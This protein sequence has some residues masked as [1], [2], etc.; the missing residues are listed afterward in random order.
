MTFFFLYIALITSSLS[1]FLTHTM[2]QPPG[3]I[4]DRIITAVKKGDL[5]QIKDIHRN[6]PTISFTHINLNGAPLIHVAAATHNVS[7][8]DYLIT[9]VGLNPKTPFH[10]QTILHTAAQEGSVPMSRYLIEK[11]ILDKNSTDLRGKTALDIAKARKKSSVINYLLLDPTVV[12]AQQLKKAHD[13]KQVLS[14][15]VTVHKHNTQCTICCEEKHFKEFSVLECEHSYCTDCITQHIIHAIASENSE[16][17]RCPTPECKKPLGPQ[18]TN[19]LLADNTPIKTKLSQL[20][21]KTWL[22]QQKNRAACPTPNCPFIFINERTDQFTM[23]CPS[24]KN[25]YCAKCNAPHCARISCEQAK[26]NKTVIADKEGQEKATQRWKEQNS[27]PCPQCNVS[28]EK[29]E[30]CNHMKCRTCKHEFCW[31]CMQPYEVK[32]HGPFGCSLAATQPAMPNPKRITNEQVSPLNYHLFFTRDP[33]G[34]KNLLSSRLIHTEFFERFKRLSCQQQ[35]EWS[36]RVSQKIENSF[37]PFFSQDKA[38]LDALESIEGIAI[39]PESDFDDSDNDSFAFLNGIRITNA[40]QLRIILGLL[41]HQHNH[42]N[43]VADPD[44]PS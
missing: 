13:K 37:S 9:Q 18:D 43:H 33:L 36:A 35:D 30:G 40:I 29:S 41:A 8:M 20:Q 23:Q 27:R 26:E 2:E 16:S 39:E 32:G 1:F 19:A 22:M 11:N 24:C 17:V 6:N 25:I 15:F 42:D 7:I 4:M 21:F 3:R 38:W 14:K 10:G 28:I 31:Q 44:E 5:A 12:L 34:F